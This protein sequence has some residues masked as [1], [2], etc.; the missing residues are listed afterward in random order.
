MNEEY[1]ERKRGEWFLCI[2]PFKGKKKRHKRIKGR[3]RRP[4]LVAHASRG[5]ERGGKKTYSVYFRQGRKRKKKL[6]KRGGTRV[7]DSSAF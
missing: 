6:G 4:R 1:Y 3:N 7:K 2:V 5:T